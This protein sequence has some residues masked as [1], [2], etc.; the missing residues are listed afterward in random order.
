MQL[1]DKLPADLDYDWYIA[2]AMEMLGNAAVPSYEQFA[3]KLTKAEQE[4]LDRV[5][6]HR[7]KYRKMK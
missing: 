2:K 3:S 7:E 4:E 6:A 5:V 1:P